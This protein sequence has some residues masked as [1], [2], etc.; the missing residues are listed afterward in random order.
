M[1][2]KVKLLGITAQDLIVVYLNGIQIVAKPES[3]EILRVRRPLFQWVPDV[4]IEVSASLKLKCE[5]AVKQMV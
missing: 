5:N 4:L 2:E 3:E 1:T